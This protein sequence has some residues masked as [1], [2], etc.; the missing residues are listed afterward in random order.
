METHPVTTLHKKSYFA[1]PN[2]L[3]NDLSD[4]NR[5]GI[6]SFFCYQE[7]WHFL[8]PKIWSYSLDR[9]W[10]IIFFKKNTWKYDIFFKYSEKMVFLKMS[11][12]NMIFFV[13]SAKMG[14]FFTQ[15]YDNFYLDGKWKMI[16][17]KKYME[18]WHFL[19]ICYKYNITF[20]TKKWKTI[21]SL[22]NT[23]KGEWHSKVT[24]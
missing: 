1:F 17:F 13:L 21:F 19:Y 18:I 15:K 12:W 5:T 3:K 7:R 11:H 20:L 16:F 6:W 24:F 10:K 22:E 14:V 8:F 23:L 9:K 2:V 4:K